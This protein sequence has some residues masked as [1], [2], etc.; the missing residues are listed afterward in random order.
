MGDALKILFSAEESANDRAAAFA[1]I[2]EA[3]VAYLLEFLGIP[4]AE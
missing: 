1:K 3:L 4:E 2:L